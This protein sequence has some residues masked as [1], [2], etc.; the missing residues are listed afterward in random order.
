M[1]NSKSVK[2][3]TRPP[4]I[5]LGIPKSIP[6][7]QREGNYSVKEKLYKIYPLLFGM[8]FRLFWNYSQEDRGRFSVPCLLYSEILFTSSLL[9]MLS[10]RLR[11]HSWSYDLMPAA[12]HARSEGSR[13]PL[14]RPLR[15]GSDQGQCFYPE[16]QSLL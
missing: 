7:K 1:K 13:L 8:N 5:Y 3:D 12:K 2:M 4:I 14:L 6:L 9:R 15:S 11:H 10:L 16:F